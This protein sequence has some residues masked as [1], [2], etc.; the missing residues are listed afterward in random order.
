MS[1]SHIIPENGD[2][3]DKKS[4]KNPYIAENDIRNL[5]EEK[6]QQAIQ[7]S[8]Q[9]MREILFAGEKPKRSNKEMAHLFAEKGYL[10]F[11]L[12]PN[13]DYPFIQ[14]WKL[15]ATTNKEQIERWWTDCPDA[16]IGVSTKNLLILEIEYCHDSKTPQFFDLYREELEFKAN[17]RELVL[18]RWR[19]FKNKNCEYRTYFYRRD[20]PLLSPYNIIDK[21]LRIIADGKYLIFS[22]EDIQKGLVP[23]LRTPPSS[24]LQL[25]INKVLRPYCCKCHALEKFQKFQNRRRGV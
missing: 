7:D 22:D 11:P 3:F 1:N 13:T 18:E 2:V 5:S 6:K 8:L 9:R 21:S 24:I 19:S 20:F 4:P 14:N 25:I 10:V 15:K 16:S 17:G 23:A 12:I